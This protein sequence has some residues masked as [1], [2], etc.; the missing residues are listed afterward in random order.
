MIVEVPEAI[1]R[2][3]SLPRLKNSWV[4]FSAKRLIVP[5]FT[6]KT[7]LLRVAGFGMRFL[8]IE[9]DE[10]S[11]IL[12]PLKD[13]SQAPFAFTVALAFSLQIEGEAMVK[14]TGASISLLSIQ[15]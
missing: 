15:S 13:W 14:R 2:Y 3:K 6:V 9:S 11:S 7:A 8:I 5:C 12:F 10:F 1:R 4:E